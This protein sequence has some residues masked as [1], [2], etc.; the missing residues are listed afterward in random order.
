MES[1]LRAQG[2]Q[3]SL[4]RL[5]RR[6]GKDAGSTSDARGHQPADS[7]FL[8]GL[9]ERLGGNFILA[10]STYS[11]TADLPDK[12]RRMNYWVYAVNHSSIP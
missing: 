6:V 5:F 4:R 9:T 8:N 10:E 1:G 7:G 2:M 11:N 3:T 12:L